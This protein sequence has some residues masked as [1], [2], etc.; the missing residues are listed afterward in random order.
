MKKTRQKLSLNRETVRLM[1]IRGG[2]GDTSDA[3]TTG[4]SVNTCPDGGCIART[5]GATMCQSCPL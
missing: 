2:G 4:G 5:C 1:E 3:G